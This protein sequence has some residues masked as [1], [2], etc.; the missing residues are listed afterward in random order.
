MNN[1]EGVLD[2]LTGII[3]SL[4]IEELDELKKY[5]PI[6]KLS[7]NMFDDTTTSS[8]VFEMAKEFLEGWIILKNQSNT[9]LE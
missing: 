6:V 8:K 3:D 7:V 5:K 1:K 4:N 2:S 9:N